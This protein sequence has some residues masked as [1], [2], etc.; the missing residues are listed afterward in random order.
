MQKTLRVGPILFLAVLGLCVAV[1][2]LVAWATDDSEISFSKAE[3]FF[4]LNNTD[5][6]LSF[7]A[8]IDGEQLKSLEISD[9]KGKRVLEIS[10]NNRLQ[11]QG[12]SELFFESVEH[13]FEE[14]LPQTFFRQY[15]KGIYEI[16]GKVLDGTQLTRQVTLTHVMP[17][18]PEP[19]VNTLPMAKQCDPEESGF[20]ITVTS[21]PVTIA[22]PAVTTSHPNSHGRG[23]DSQ[24]PVSVEIHHYEVE[25]EVVNGALPSLLNVILPPS[26]TSITIPEEFISL[27][28]EFKYEV[29]VSENSF[30][31]TEIE[32]CF[33][34]K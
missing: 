14:I 11:S 4:E 16:T 25:V 2:V 22:W 18:S 23:A 34:L 5:G 26:E 17:A 9:S 6:D 10:V 24:L 19:T 29:V 1:S 33:T 32:S 21:A 12:F 30:N 28:K 15:P 27:G 8:L 13:G 31:Q 7:H 20:D 3:L